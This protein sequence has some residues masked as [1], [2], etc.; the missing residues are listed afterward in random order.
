MNFLPLLTPPRPP[1]PPPPA[2][3]VRPRRCS[4]LCRRA[5]PPPPLPPLNL[6]PY[7]RV[8]G[9]T[10]PPRRATPASRRC[11]SGSRR[12]SCQ[13][14]VE[15]CGGGG[16]PVGVVAVA[17]PPRPVG[18]TPTAVVEPLRSGGCGTPVTVVEPPCAGG[19]TCGTPVSVVELFTGQP[20]GIGHPVTGAA[21]APCSSKL[22]PRPPTSA[23]NH[24]PR[25]PARCTWSSTD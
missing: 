9:S 23:T 12:N 1:R 5:P 7:S 18:G 8:V 3:V 4:L 22:P 16:A 20:F 2:V 13:C 15:P 6:P 25:H 11:Y 19:G 21:P 17:E 24:P 10:A 14:V